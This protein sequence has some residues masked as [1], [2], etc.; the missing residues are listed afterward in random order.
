MI[1]SYSDQP[2]PGDYDGD[3]TKDI[4]IFRSVSGRPRELHGLISEAVEKI[5][6]LYDSAEQLDI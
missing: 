3:G 4:S 1:G 6:W 2:N 5:D